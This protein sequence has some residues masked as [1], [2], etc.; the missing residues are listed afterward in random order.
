MRIRRLVLTSFLF[1]EEIIQVYSYRKEPTTE[2]NVSTFL[3]KPLNSKPNLTFSSA[4]SVSQGEAWI[5]SF[6]NFISNL[7]LWMSVT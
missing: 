5:V 7:R 4:P 6:L 3:K 2:R 1:W